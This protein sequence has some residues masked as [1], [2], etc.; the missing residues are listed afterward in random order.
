MLLKSMGQ[1]GIVGRSCRLAYAAMTVPICRRRVEI[2]VVGE[3]D[4]D[5]PVD[6]VRRD[7]P[8]VG[9]GIGPVELLLRLVLRHLPPLERWRL[10]VPAGEFHR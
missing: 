10:G 5:D 7:G 6:A 1:K 4:L 9:G 8:D 2:D 3:G